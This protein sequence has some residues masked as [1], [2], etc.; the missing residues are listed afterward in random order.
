MCYALALTQNLAPV[1]MAAA[2]AAAMV[3]VVGYLFRTK[4]LWR[5]I[6]NI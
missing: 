4:F 5:F 1:V 3:V 2:A 6:N